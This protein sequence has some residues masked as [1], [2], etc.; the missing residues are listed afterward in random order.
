[1]I[2][3]GANPHVIAYDGDSEYDRH[4]LSGLS[5]IPTTKSYTFSCVSWVLFVDTEP[6][7]A[8]DWPSIVIELFAS[9][10]FAILVYADIVFGILIAAHFVLQSQV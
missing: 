4:S 7:N 5:N 9:L 3:M 8:T 1:M 2:D 6:P 10:A